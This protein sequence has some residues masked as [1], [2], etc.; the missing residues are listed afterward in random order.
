M[1]FCTRAEHE[2]FLEAVP[3]FERMLVRSRMFVLKYYLDISRGEQARRLRARRRDPLKQWKLSPLDA[4][5]Q[6]HWR[7]YSRARDSMFRRTHQPEAPWIVIRAD[8]QHQV[9]LNVIR[10][11][12]ASP[13]RD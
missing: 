4:A 6:R 3:R 7:D 1:K 2:A 12:R 8:D 10:D 5:A 9:R 13:H 11:M